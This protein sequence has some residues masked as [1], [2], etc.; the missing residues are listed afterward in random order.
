VATPTTEPIDGWTSISTG[1]LGFIEHPFAIGFTDD[2]ER[3]VAVDHDD[4]AFVI[5]LRNGSIAEIREELADDDTFIGGF[6]PC[7]RYLA[8]RDFGC[9]DVFSRDAAFAEAAR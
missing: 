9:L 6:S 3:L 5:V 8:V 7:G 4:C 2:G 1:A